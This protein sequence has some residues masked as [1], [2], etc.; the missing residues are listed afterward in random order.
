LRCIVCKMHTMRW[1]NIDITRIKRFRAIYATY[2]LDLSRYY[3]VG[4]NKALI[5]AL[6]PIDAAAVRQCSFHQLDE[7]CAIK[8]PT[9]KLTNGKMRKYRSNPR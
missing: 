2:K 1:S 7:K 4:R 8:I 5:E 6:R 9:W 3:F